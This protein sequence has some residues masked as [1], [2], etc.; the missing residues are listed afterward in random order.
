MCTCI[1]KT[2]ERERN[3]VVFFVFLFLRAGLNING[4]HGILIT[5][6]YNENGIVPL[7]LII[8]SNNLVFFQNLIFCTVISILFYYKIYCRMFFVSNL[9]YFVNNV[10]YHIISETICI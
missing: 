5:I 10:N 3:L 2:K 4:F 9:I 8:I 6:S 1:Y 7:M